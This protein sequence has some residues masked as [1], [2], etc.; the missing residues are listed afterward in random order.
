MSKR[1][2]YDVPRLVDLSAESAIAAICDTFGDDATDYQCR[3]GS[4][5]TSSRCSTGTYCQW[6]YSGPVAHDSLV[7]GCWA[8]CQTGTSVSSPGYTCKCTTGMGATWDCA[9]GG[10]AGEA[11]CSGGG[12]VMNC[13]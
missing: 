12:S 10:N 8:C 4:C 11:N 2:K 3:E 6:C 1:F 7:S 9:Y 5:P 13:A